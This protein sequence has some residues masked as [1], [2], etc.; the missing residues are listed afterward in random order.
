MIKD[1]LEYQ[2]TQEWVEKFE[3][4][5]ATLE[6]DDTKKKNDPDGWELVRRSLQSH[7]DALQAEI[8]EYETLKN[9]DYHTPIVLKLDNIDYLSQI[10]IK[11]RIAA[12]LTQQEL[13]DLAGLT[14][15][16]IKLYEAKDYEDASFLDM[17]AVIDALNIRIQRC[18][19]LVTLDTLRRTPITKEELLSKTKTMATK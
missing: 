2:I 18:E 4:S 13:A 5:I 15:E 11:A 12:Q 19:F 9:H 6:Q 8:Y 17:R 3:T 1:E 14:E 16:R 10:L 7:L